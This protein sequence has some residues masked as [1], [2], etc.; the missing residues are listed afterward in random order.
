MRKLTLTL[1]ALTAVALAACA[2]S[3]PKSAPLP[4]RV[5]DTACDWVPALSA[6][7]SDTEET[8][9]EVV[10]YETARQTNCRNHHSA[11]KTTSGG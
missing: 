9:R 2:P 10:A 4:P 7:A 3:C 1:F 6:S 11:H 5:I 8:R